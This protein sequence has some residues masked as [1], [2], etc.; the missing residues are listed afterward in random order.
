MIFLQLFVTFF[1]IGLF[2]FGG[3][4]AMLSLI[5]GE[6]VTKTHWLTTAQFTDIVA[7][8]QSTPGPI[9]INSATYVG[10]LSVVNAGYS[11][12][13]AIL[14]SCLATLAVVLPSFLLVL[15]ALKILNRY[16]T[17]PV[18]EFMFQ[19]LRITVVGLLGGAVVVLLTAE[20]F[21]SPSVDMW[22]YV[23]SVFLFVAAFVGTYV[24][25]IHPI[26][27]IVLCG[28]AGLVMYL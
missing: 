15:L 17:H 8:S 2:G 1:K 25:K 10:Y 23:T 16:Y 13:M 5:Q 14:G 28:I 24:F 27:M 9:G 6:V 18:V 7:I 11:T 19:V 26:R 12:P 4:Y 20:N 21:G 3:G 22:Q